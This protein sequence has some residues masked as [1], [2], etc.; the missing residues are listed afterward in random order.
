MGLLYKFSPAAYWYRPAG[1][2]SGPLITPMFK[3][4][5]TGSGKEKVYGEDLLRYLAAINSAKGYAHIISATYGPS[6]G[7]RAKGKKIRMVMAV[8]PG[9]DN[10]VMIERVIGNWGIV[11]GLDEDKIP[12][13][14]IT[15]DTHPHLIHRVYGSN[16]IGTAVRLKDDI[17]MPVLS[18]G[19]FIQMKWL[20]RI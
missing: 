9:P 18:S 10:L 13:R 6:R 3:K 14:N 19:R 20:E 11:Q 4:M 1:N 7:L 15:H 5:K 16:R 12:A 17:F 8:Y 2:T